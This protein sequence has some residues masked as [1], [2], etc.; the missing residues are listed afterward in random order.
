MRV[1][2]KHKSNG[3]GQMI[4]DD[5]E[6]TREVIATYLGG[7]VKTQGGDIWKVANFGKGWETVE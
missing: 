3:R 5:R 4:R 6:T 2:I 1:T 7:K